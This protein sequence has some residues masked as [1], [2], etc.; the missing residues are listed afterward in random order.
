MGFLPTDTVTTLKVTFHHPYSL[1][2]IIDSNIKLD[3]RDFIRKLLKDSSEQCIG[4]G[5]YPFKNTSYPFNIAQFGANLTGD[6]Y[7][8][9]SFI[10]TFNPAQLKI[11]IEGNLLKKTIVRKVKNAR[12]TP[13][14]FVW[15]GGDKVIIE[16]I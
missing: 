10:F 1:F 3:S 8:G 14:A 13:V 7:S 9:D 4:Y 2:G 11:T 6:A 15:S 16:I 12:Y 5:I